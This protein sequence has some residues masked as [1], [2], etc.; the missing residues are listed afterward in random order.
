MHRL[1]VCLLCA[2]PLL[3]AHR[4]LLAYVNPLIETQQQTEQQQAPVLFLAEELKRSGL[5]AVCASVETVYEDEAQVPL[6]MPPTLAVFLDLFRSENSIPDAIA[7]FRN[8]FSPARSAFRA[9]E[10]DFTSAASLKERLKIKRRV[11]DVAKFTESRY[12]QT[13]TL[14]ESVVG[15]APEVLKPLSNPHDPSKYSKELIAKP[16]EWIRNWWVRRPFRHVY[17]VLDRLHEIE[18]YE[19]LVPNILGYHITPEDK[20]TFVAA[21][22]E[23]L[24][25]YGLAA[26][27]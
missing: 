26:S 3:G 16:V 24:T 22:S 2:P 7:A 23:Y 21:Y 6:A 11:R 5:T 14:V 15:F 20:R 10:R 17:S 27:K 12:T 18:G 1:L 9:L 8:C 13:T 4:D 19:D 25:M